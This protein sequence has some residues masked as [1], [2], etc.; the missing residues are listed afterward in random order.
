[1]ITLETGRRHRG[2]LDALNQFLLHQLIVGETLCC[3]FSQA[4]CAN[5]ISPWSRS[6]CDAA[7]GAFPFLDRLCGHRDPTKETTA[8][9]STTRSTSTADQKSV[10]TTTPNSPE[11]CVPDW[12]QCSDT[13]GCCSDPEWLAQPVCTCSKYSREG[14]QVDPL[15]SNQTWYCQDGDR[16]KDR[17]KRGHCKLDTPEVDCRFDANTYTLLGQDTTTDADTVSPSLYTPYLPTP[18][19]WCIVLNYAWPRSSVLSICSCDVHRHVVDALYSFFAPLY[20]FDS[21]TFRAIPHP[22][23]GVQYPVHPKLHGM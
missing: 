13:V 22:F 2:R 14:T 8:E 21:H 10:P 6:A 3:I 4:H 1:M 23:R 9:T 19:R 12:S 16:C 17:G 11:I 18:H 20:T 7:L 15:S 5:I